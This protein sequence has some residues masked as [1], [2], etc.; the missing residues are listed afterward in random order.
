M[1]VT[2][3]EQKKVERLLNQIY[4]NELAKKLGADSVCVRIILGKICNGRCQRSHDRIP[5]ELLFAVTEV[6]KEKVNLDV[7]LPHAQDLWRKFRQM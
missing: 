5:T 6:V 2:A 1:R 7:R 4:V 3:E